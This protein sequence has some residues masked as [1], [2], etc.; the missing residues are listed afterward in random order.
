VLVH[1]RHA[2]GLF[3]V[4][5]ATTEGALIRSYE[6]GMVALTRAGGVETA[7]LADE[8]HIAPSFFFDTVAAAE[9]FTMVSD[10]P[11]ALAAAA[12]SSSMVTPV[13]TRTPRGPSV[14]LG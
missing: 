12:S 2:Q 5:M 4:P 7:L 6:R 13:P 1:G 11:V 3:Y 14:P 8:N 9:R 10:M